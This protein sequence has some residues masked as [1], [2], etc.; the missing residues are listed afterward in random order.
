[1]ESASIG[2]GVI[3]IKKQSAIES[4]DDLIKNTKAKFILISYNN[5]GIIPF[6]TFKSILEKYGK[7]ELL[8]Q[9]YNTYRG[10][11]NL[12]DRSIKVKELLWVLEKNG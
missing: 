11:R 10:C 5:E 4:M 3:I 1:M 6:D 9:D 7:V 8:Q 2:I 12:H